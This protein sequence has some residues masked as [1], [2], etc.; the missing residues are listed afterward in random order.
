[1][2]PTK[3]SQEPGLGNI[4]SK[5]KKPKGGPEENKREK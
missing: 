1:M 2:I 5:K 3:G 4:K